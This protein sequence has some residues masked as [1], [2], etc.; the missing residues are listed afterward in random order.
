[1]IKSSF[2]VTLLFAVFMLMTACADYQPSQINYGKESCAY[3]KMN[4]VEKQFGTQLINKKGKKYYFDSIECL[5]A[6]TI[7]QEELK[8]NTHSMWVTN[9]E[10]PDQFINIEDAIFLYGGTVHSPMGIGLLAV[11]DDM[12]AQKLL[13]TFGAEIIDW[14]KTNEIVKY[15]WDL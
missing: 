14:Q 10:Q 6:I 12:Q 8:N 1:M 13:N 7:K 4:I 15:T 11:R 2:I 5:A 3:C 9:F